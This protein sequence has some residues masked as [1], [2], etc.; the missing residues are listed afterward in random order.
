MK[1]AEMMASLI[2]QIFFHYSP[3]S[4]SL[5]VIHSAILVVILEVGT[6]IV[7]LLVSTGGPFYHF[8]DHARP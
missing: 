7:D 5:F 6:Y 3:P 2:N 8:Q 1:L 4:I